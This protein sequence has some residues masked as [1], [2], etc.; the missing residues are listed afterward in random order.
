MSIGTRPFELLHTTLRQ[1]SRSGQISRH[2]CGGIRRPL[3]ID[4]TGNGLDAVGDDIGQSLGSVAPS[5]PPVRLPDF[6][7]RCSRLHP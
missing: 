5:R 3:R 7:D 2:G 6:H 1:P 4:W